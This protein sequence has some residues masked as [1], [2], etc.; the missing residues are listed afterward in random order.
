MNVLQNQSSSLS[1]SNTQSGK[2]QDLI[3]IFFS[4]S[5][6]LRSAPA[7]R[8]QLRDSLKPKGSRALLKNPKVYFTTLLSR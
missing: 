2:W 6:S 8:L 3:L 1:A 5:L 7:S 4:S